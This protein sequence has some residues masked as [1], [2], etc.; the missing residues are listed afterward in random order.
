MRSLANEAYSLEGGI[1]FLPNN[2]IFLNVKINIQIKD[3][4][5][6]EIVFPLFCANL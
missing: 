1:L 5:P 3:I 6:M 4:K 2:H